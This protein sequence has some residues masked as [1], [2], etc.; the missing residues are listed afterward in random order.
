MA[1][2]FG[3][4]Q[5]TR[6]LQQMGLKISHMDYSRNTIELVF[7]DKQGQWKMIV[8]IHQSGETSKLMLIVPHFSSLGETKRLECLEA[9][10]SVNYRIA[11][12]KFGVDLSDGEVRL[13]ES[14]PLANG[15][16]TI[17]QFR[18]AF[19]AITQTVSIYH[20]LLSRIIYGHTS[21]LDALQACEQ[22]FFQSPR[23]EL[24]IATTEQQATQDSVPTTV[25][26]EEPQKAVA[27]LDV[28][29]I[30]A[31]AA[32]LLGIHQD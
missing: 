1:E 30:L 23:A 4:L 16:L 6:Y 13:E 29:E 26:A 9:L 17:E 21:V 14:I 32:W 15:E 27:E 10:M 5:I 22:E 31:E 20:N 11:I 3:I 8:G 2:N 12:G 7:H 19:S 24:E 28:N 18:L 25:Q